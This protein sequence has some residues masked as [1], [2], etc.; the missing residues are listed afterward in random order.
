MR[1]LTTMADAA[2]ALGVEVSF[3]TPRATRTFAM[4][5]YPICGTCEML[6]VLRQHRPIIGDAAFRD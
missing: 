5:S 2:R 6:D 1:A 4:P 3:L